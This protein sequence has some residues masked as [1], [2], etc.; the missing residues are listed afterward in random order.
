M[1][2]NQIITAVLAVGLSFGAYAASPARALMLPEGAHHPVIS[3]DGTRLLF[4]TDVHTGL[5]SLD[6][7]TGI[8]SVID[9]AAA[10]G[11]QPVFSADGSTVFYRTAKIDDGLMYCDVR[12]FTFDKKEMR[13]LA[14]YSRN[15]ENL[16][17]L[18]GKNYAYSD[19]KTI[20][21]CIDGVIKDLNPIADSHSY[22]W[23]SLSADGRHILFTEPFKGVF[24]ADIN[25]TNQKKIL[26]KGS[27]AS[28]AGDDTIIAVISHDDGYVVT[29]S[30]L[31]A[32]NVTTGKI[33]DLTSSD[34]IVGEA[35]ASFDGKVVFTDIKGKMF[36]INL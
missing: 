11:F 28:W 33:T 35:T 4:S 30:R 32:V 24:V 9:D 10:A 6:L 19:Y 5:R 25:G 31:V 16:S 20:K 17:A 7:T 27:F 15:S 14:A 1:K 21:V 29:D 22:L 3:P 2:I 34:I 18:T 23:S 8:V 12:S 26:D 13:K 36:I